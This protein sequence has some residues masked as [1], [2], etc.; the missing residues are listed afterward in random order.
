[1]V[2]RASSLV[3]RA[4]PRTAPYLGSQVCGAGRALRDLRTPRTG[5]PC[6][7]AVTIA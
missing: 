6:H 2:R 5:R 1:M 4:D 7:A 3:S